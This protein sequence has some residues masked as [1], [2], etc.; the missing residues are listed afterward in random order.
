M[1][2]NTWFNTH[3]KKHKAIMQKL[4]ELSM[5]EVISYFRFENM[6]KNEPHF[7]PLYKQK[8]KCHNM[9]KL[10]CY[11]CAC[12]HFRFSDIGS[13]TNN[14]PIV[15]S[16][17][18][19]NAKDGAVFKSKTAVHQDCSACLLPHRESYIKKIFSRDWVEIMKEVKC[20]SGSLTS[21][22]DRNYSSLSYF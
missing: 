20:N 2:Y 10:N 21:K 8:I 13:K 1:T 15:Y 7:C 18:S 19:I 3:A 4:K 5:D 16:S 12:P 11:L 22:K 14:T 17:C 9:K 6:L